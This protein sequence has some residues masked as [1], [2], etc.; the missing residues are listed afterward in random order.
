MCGATARVHN[1]T[2]LML[3]AI[4][5][6]A[7]PPAGRRVAPL[8]DPA[9]SA[10]LLTRM[11]RPPNCSTT[12]A[13]IC[14]VATTSVT[15]T[16]TYTAL[17]PASVNIGLDRSTLVL[18][19]V[20]DDDAGTGQ[21][22]TTGVTPLRSRGARDDHD[23]AGEIECVAHITSESEGR[24]FVGLALHR[25]HALQNTSTNAMLKWFRGISS[26]GTGRATSSTVGPISSAIVCSVVEVEAVERGRVREVIAGPRPPGRRRMRAQAELVC[27]KVPSWCG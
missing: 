24:D 11:S 26:V 22:Q 12:V 2:P 20:G 17:P 19:N 7:G 27:G 1:H 8:A 13:A 21:P 6:S 4:S 5:R 16:V 9:N 23:L 14:S 3:I 10:A 15:S 18:S 25:G